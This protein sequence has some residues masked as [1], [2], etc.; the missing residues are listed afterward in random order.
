MTPKELR[1]LLPPLSLLL[2]PFH[3][4]LLASNALASFDHNASLVLLPPSTSLHATLTP[5]L[6]PSLPTLLSTSPSFPSSLSMYLSRLP[7]PR[8]MRLSLPSHSLLTACLC[9]QPS[10]HSLSPSLSA[11]LPLFPCLYSLLSLFC[12][13]ACGSCGLFSY[14]NFPIFLGFFACFAVVIVVLPLVV[15]I[16]L[17]AVVVVFIGIVV[18]AFV[19]CNCRQLLPLV[20]VTLNVKSK[21]CPR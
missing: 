5:F 1:L 16:L 17:V 21:S 3:L 10:T 20:E 13:P 19:G 11:S 18:V 2:P 7:L 14:C 6:T 4:P 12:L 15:V 8:S 9:L